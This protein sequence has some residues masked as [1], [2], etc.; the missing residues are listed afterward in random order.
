MIRKSTVVRVEILSG[1]T[2]LRQICDTPAL[3]M[4]YAGDSGKLDSLRELLSQ[5]KESDHRVL[6]FSQFRGMLDITEGLLQE[7]GDFQ[8]NRVNAI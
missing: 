6:I 1:I 8:A 3:F 2:R 7:L 4:D 5:I